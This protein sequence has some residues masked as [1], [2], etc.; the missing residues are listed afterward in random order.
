MSGI[1]EYCLTVDKIFMWLEYCVCVA[2]LLCFCGQTILFLWLEFCVYVTG[3]VC[4]YGW[5]IV[6]MWLEYC[7]YVVGILCLTVVFKF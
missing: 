2:G 1:L 6:F 5:N 4:L 7:V 3:I